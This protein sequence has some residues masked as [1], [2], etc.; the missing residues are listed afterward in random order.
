MDNGQIAGI[1]TERDLLKR[2]LEE[3][4]DPKETRVSER[5]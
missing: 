4:K 3:Y 5:M 1:L 2:V